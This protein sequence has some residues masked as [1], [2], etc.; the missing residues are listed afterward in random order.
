VLFKCKG[1]FPHE[2][3]LWDHGLGRYPSSWAPTWLTAGKILGVAWQCGLPQ[4]PPPAPWPLP[5][6][7]PR[8]SRTAAATLLPSHLPC[9]LCL[10]CWIK[11]ERG[12][13]Q[14]RL[15]TW[16]S[17]P[18]ALRPPCSFRTRWEDNRANPKQMPHRSVGAVPRWWVRVPCHTPQSLPRK[19][20]WVG[21]LQELSSTVKALQF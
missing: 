13:G 19:L 18:Y 17:V 11:P 12:Q 2:K 4:V 15:Q 7:L 3:H 14:V 9:R 6:L 21:V 1:K 5:L 20:P 8:P 16:A 10:I